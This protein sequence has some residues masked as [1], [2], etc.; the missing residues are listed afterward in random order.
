MWHDVKSWMCDVSS[1]PF[2]SISN[3]IDFAVAMYNL[4]E[5]LPSGTCQ[6]KWDFS[7]SENRFWCVQANGVNT[8]P[9]TTNH[10]IVFQLVSVWRDIVVKHIRNIS[11][12]KREKERE[13]RCAFN[14]LKFDL[15]ENRCYR[16]NFVWWV[17]AT[18]GGGNEKFV[19][20]NAG[21]S[22]RVYLHACYVTKNIFSSAG[23]QSFWSSVFIKHWD[24]RRELRI[25]VKCYRNLTAGAEPVALCV[26]VCVHENVPMWECWQ[27]HFFRSQATQ[28]S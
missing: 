18:C 25:G 27:Q 28:N 23:E 1:V 16:I 10:L 24:S 5:L 26:C 8:N 21:L 14:D 3:W 11:Y 13:K 12:A 15:N 22:A 7:Y 2:D 9:P 17:E 6:P 4:E 20:I 19:M